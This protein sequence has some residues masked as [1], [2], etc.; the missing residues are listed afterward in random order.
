MTTDKKQHNKLIKDMGAVF[1]PVFYIFSIV[2]VAS[3]VIVCGFERA[4][5][6]TAIFL[7][8]L[9]ACAASDINKGIVPDLICIL[10]AVLAVVKILTGSVNMQS[11]INH[12][13]GAL[14]LSVPMLIVALLIKKGFG[15]GDIKMMAAAGLFLGLDKTITA[16]FI[17]FFIA[18]ICGVYLLFTK[19][20]SAKEKVKLAPYLALGCAFSEL[21][22]TVLIEII[23]L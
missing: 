16:G 20:G 4:A 18:G 15:G 14:V 22:G 19:K 7:V 3:A 5:V 13:C 17:A 21:F 1:T 8:M 10:I 2:A 11:L 9:A 6:I 23:G 12:L